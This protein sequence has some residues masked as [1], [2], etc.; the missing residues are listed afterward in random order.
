MAVTKTIGPLHL[1]DLEPHRF[2]DLIR[3][4]LY[5][6][7][8]WRD[9]E[10]TGRT[11]SDEGFDVRAWEV[12]SPVPEAADDQ[13]Q[14]EP[15]IARHW[16]I[17]CKR[18]KAIGPKKLQS[19][20]EGLSSAHE[21]GIY[22]LIFVAACDFSIAA[23]DA[24]YSRS[25]ELG[26]QEVKIWGKAEIEDQLFQPKNDNLLFAYFGVSLQVRRRSIQAAIRSRLTM[27]RKARK[28]LE[29]H[30]SVVL[31]DATD[32]RYPHLDPDTTLSRTARGRWAVAQVHSLHVRG[33]RL[34]YRRHFAFVDDN[35]VGW[36]FAERMNDAIPHEDPWRSDG[37]PYER[38]SQYRHEDAEKWMKLESRN[39][40]WYE[41]QAV[42][43]WEAIIDI[44]PEGDDDEFRG[45]VIY[46]QSFNN[47]GR[48]PLA[49]YS[50]YRLN[51]DDWSPNVNPNP[52]TR[53]EIFDRNPASVESL[54]TFLGIRRTM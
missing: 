32:E 47:E 51:V 48:P 27:K 14:T 38:A 22:G 16:L 6:F 19:Y 53:I 34:A 36:D 7:R 24:F 1:E 43:P 49:D 11:G 33:V 41:V 8:P 28:A 9:L 21:A 2:E 3:Q 15:S 50:Y 39:K 46:T 18:E 52:E 44:D 12:I 40:G 35:G 29:P 20:L 26:F 42:L 17:Q 13:E 45:S 23:R 4:L 30:T 25:R 10:A 54:P 5:D 31:L 37:D